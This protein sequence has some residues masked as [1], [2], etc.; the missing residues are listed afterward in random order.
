MIRFF[1]EKVNTLKF[2]ITFWKQFR[3]TE[4]KTWQFLLFTGLCS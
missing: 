4:N 2:V 3:Y 1:V